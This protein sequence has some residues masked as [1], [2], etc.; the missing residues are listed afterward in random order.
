[1]SN[2]SDDS[3]LSRRTLMKLGGTAIA[4][5]WGGTEIF[6]A[7]QQA[8]ISSTVKPLIVA[9]ENADIAGL[10]RAENLFW[11]D[12]MMEHASF[13]ATLMPGA[14]LSS[15]RGEAEKFQRVFQSQYDRAKSTP[16]DRTTYA[17]FNRSTVEALKPFIDYKRRMLEAQ[18]SG[19]LRSLVY[20]MFFEHTAREAEHAL[21][22]FEKL[23]SGDIALSYADLIDFW[24][25]DISDHNALIAHMLDPQ[26]QDFISE[27]LDSSAVF[28]GFNQG[29][30]DRGLARAEVVRATEDFIDFESTLG[31]GVDSGRIKSVLN[32]ALLDHMRR[33]TLKFLDELKRTGTRT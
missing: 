25:E 18:N 3:T 5:I 24:S 4:G 8:P 21:R 22:R 7:A 20:P 27:A 23:A 6:A 12:V 11:C 19:K 28:K 15:Q 32:P 14:D 13:F 9:P 31:E 29:N 16:I 10:S 33:E 1:M 17:A 30:K 26:E 2:R